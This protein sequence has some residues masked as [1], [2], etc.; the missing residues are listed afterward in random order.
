MYKRY[1]RIIFFQDGYSGPMCS[2]QIDFSSKC[3]GGEFYNEDDDSCISCFCMGIPS[4]IQG[5]VTRF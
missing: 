2:N 3:N 5:S 1:K 4:D